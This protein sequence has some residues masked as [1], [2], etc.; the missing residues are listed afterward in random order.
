[1]EYSFEKLIAYRT[2]RRLVKEVYYLIQK[3][4]SEE[5]FALCDQ[6]RRS[7]ISVPSNIAEQSG[8]TSIK[9]RCHFLDI[10]YGSL[11]EAYCQLEIAVDLGYITYE[12]LKMI[13]EPF[14]ETSR[15][16]LGLKKSFSSKTE[17]C[18]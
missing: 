13:K 9:E 3:F 14:F 10:A 16:L 5:R 1:M 8:R 7:V 12:D 18:Q 2:A 17:S 6:L 4:P 11:M 15:L